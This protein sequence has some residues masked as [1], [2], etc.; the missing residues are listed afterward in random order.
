MV[1]GLS[2]SGGGRFPNSA[3]DITDAGC[4]SVAEFW[5]LV[6]GVNRGASN[7]SGDGVIFAESVGGAMVSSGG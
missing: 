7:S 1:K 2:G 5:M 4:A 3:L 6:F